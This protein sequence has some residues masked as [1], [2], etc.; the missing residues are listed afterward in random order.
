MS[1]ELQKQTIS[2]FGDQWTRYT[3]NDGFYGSQEFFADIVRPLLDVSEFQGA[4]VAEIGSGT[5]RIAQMILKSGARKVLAIEPSEA[6]S[7]MRENLA[8][9]GE[10]AE[11][12]KA[13]GENIPAGADFDYVLSIGVLHHIPDPGP[14]VRASLGA[15]K[16]GG[17]MLVW[18]YGKEGN[19]LYLAI[20]NPLRYITQRI[21]HWLLVSMIW[22]MYPLL[23]GYMLACRI[24]PLPM[25]RY[26]VDVVAKMKPAKRRL[27][28]YDQLNPAYAKYYTHDEAIA[29]LAENGF[30]DVQAHHRHGYSWTVIGAK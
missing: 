29:L 22:A 1:Q 15:L 6:F 18:L 2:D 7:V 13:T 28:A 14:S 11:G 16:P 5:G 3:D 25:R 10:R 24:L 4:A 12:L 26:M 23:V 19:E 21:P 20:I 30:R 17:R 8:Q 27:I 9:Y